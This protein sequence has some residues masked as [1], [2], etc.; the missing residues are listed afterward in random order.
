MTH[1]PSSFFPIFSESSHDKDVAKNKFL[2]SL[3][4]TRGPQYIAPKRDARGHSFAQPARPTS[5]RALASSPLKQCV[6]PVI[7]LAQT[8]ASTLTWGAGQK[9]KRSALRPQLL[10]H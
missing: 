2:S 6:V 1:F 9:K 5:F 4:K 7:F 8:D 3:I 10:Q